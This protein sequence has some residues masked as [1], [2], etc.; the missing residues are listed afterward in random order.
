MSEEA[1]S[2]GNVDDRSQSNDNESASASA[3]TLALAAVHDVYEE[4]D[5]EWHCADDE[6]T[7]RRLSA[8]DPDIAGLQVILR[9]T[10]DQDYMKSLGLLVSQSTQL[11]LLN[12]QGINQLPP[13]GLPSFFMG[14][15]KNRSI[16]ELDLCQYDHSHMNI[17]TTLGPFFELNDNLRCIDI[18]DSFNLSNRTPSL[19]KSFL[20][21]NNN[22]QRIRL[23]NND[24]GDRKAANIIKAIIMMPGLPSLLELCLGGNNIGR[25]SCT[26]LANLLK[27]E[28]SN[29]QRLDLP[30]NDLDNACLHILTVGL[31]STTSF[32]HLDLRCQYPYYESVDW[33]RFI[34][35]VYSQ[36]NCSLQTIDIGENKLGDGGATA[37]G[38]SLSV[39]NKVKVVDIAGSRS[40]TLKGWGGFTKCLE[41]PIC[42][43]EELIFRSCRI[44]DEG[45]I[46][47][48][49][50]L[51]HNE[52]VKSL[53]MEDN[54]SITSTGWI[55]FIRLLMQRETSL[56]KLELS[57]NNINGAGA[58]YL[59]DLISDCMTSVEHL[60]VSNNY[61]IRASNWRV[62]AYVL[63]P[64]ST[65]KLKLLSLFSMDDDMLTDEDTELLFANLAN[66]TTLETLTL[67]NYISDRGWR[68]VATALCDDSD[69]ISTFNSNHTLTTILCT[70]SR[71]K[72]D[73]D[74]LL[75]MNRVTDKFEVAR[76]KI[77]DHHHYY[78]DDD[79]IFRIFG[80]VDATILPTALSWIG[81][82][83]EDYDMMYHFLRSMPWL[84]HHPVLE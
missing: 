84:L 47:I 50:A 68:A 43:V 14:I 10:D 33:F 38:A 30:S 41:S 67:C 46:E 16:E 27:M 74:T 24:I 37:L 13:Y 11:R 17:F 19:N 66:N 51:V 63:Q 80:S 7:M 8:N 21:T 60:A 44:D 78:L 64:S 65:S 2:R 20:K 5:V 76:W 39:N 31:A 81:R 71:S 1:K 48:A 4:P 3:S 18:S 34:S 70:Y 52:S 32:R 42:T 77:L 12:V 54:P 55:H 36:Q 9:D 45:A 35:N 72:N 58:E 6:E 79:P 69:I 29:L 25:S 59:V 56:V 15:A 53:S 49:E 57:S 23:A 26:K 40:I 28:E 83:P 75:M 62:F 82:H 73:V 22:L 61:A